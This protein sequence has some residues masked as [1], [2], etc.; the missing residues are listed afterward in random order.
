MRMTV[1]VNDINDF[2]IKIVGGPYLGSGRGSSTKWD[3]LCPYCQNTF[4][5][6]T[7]KFKKSKS[8]YDCRGKV[9]RKSSE[10]ITWKNHYGMVKGRKHS[11]EKGFDLTLEQF[12]EI[13]K[14]NCF[15]CNSEPTPTKGHRQWSTIIYTNGLDR[16]DSN[17]GYLYNNVVPCCIY[18]NT[19]K[20]DR[21][22]EEFYSWVMKLAKHIKTNM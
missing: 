19:A 20:L 2:N 6:P 12:I 16:I 4:I 11:K 5:A 10:L 15:Y 14:K 17:M 1:K 8:C 9:L 18:C 3:F 21:T 7:T 13:S 22:Q